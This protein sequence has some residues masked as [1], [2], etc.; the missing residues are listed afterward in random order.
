[1]TEENIVSTNTTFD[2]YLD[3]SYADQIINLIKKAPSM[4]EVQQVIDKYYPTWIVKKIPKYSKD[5]ELLNLTWRNMARQLRC[6][7][8][9]ILLVESIEFD[10]KHTVINI[11]GEI[12]TKIGFSVR[13]IDEIIPCRVCGF[14]IPNRMLYNEMKKRRD[15]YETGKIKNATTF[16]NTCP[17]EWSDCCCS[18]K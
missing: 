2:K 15:D 7:R 4:K 17:D 10:E 9:E 14:G 6:K 1:M 13:R 5:Y 8:Q 3:P 11:L 18:C 12:F 16:S